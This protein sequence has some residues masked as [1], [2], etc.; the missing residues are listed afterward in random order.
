MATESIK[1]APTDLLGQIRQGD[2]KFLQGL[3]DKYRD[4]FVLW[5][6]KNY[7]CDDDMAA[8]VYQQTFI[9]LFYNV[10]NQKLTQLN[11]SLKTYLFAIGKNLLRD[12]FKI[13]QRRQQI[14][15]VA[16]DTSEMDNS[17]IERYEQ[18]NMKCVVRELLLKIGEPCKTVLEL[19]YFQNYS[20]DSIA[21]TMDYKTEQIAAKR[22][23]I[24]LRQMRSL[25]LEAQQQDEI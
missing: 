8:E 4:E 21:Q 15:Q 1:D 13:L 25:L 2:R 14:L 19:F 11:S 24:C 20:M 16:V 18:S 6:S 5:A 22:K 17:I 9:T 10:K 23:F 3:Y 12:Q 7:R